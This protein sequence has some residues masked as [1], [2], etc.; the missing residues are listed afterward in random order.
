MT[1]DAAGVGC[2]GA[3]VIALAARSGGLEVVVGGIVALVDV[4]VG[5]GGNETAAD[6]V[7][8]G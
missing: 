5:A 2:T 3:G 6:A 7:G 1:F 4:V 8:R